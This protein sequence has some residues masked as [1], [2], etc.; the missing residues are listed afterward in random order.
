METVESIFLVLAYVA[1][2]GFLISGM[3]DLFFD[4]QFLVYLWRHRRQPH[5]TLN[6][7]KL[8]PEQWIA[9]FVPAWHEGGVVNKMAE[10]AARVL[11][12]ERYDIFI[13]VYP[14]DPHT[15]E[16]V[17]AIC[18]ANPRI[19]K[20]RV[21]HDGPTNKADCLNWIYRAMRLN[22]V[23][24]TREYKL[25]AI[26]DAEDVLHPLVLKV[27]NY[28]VPRHYDMA[29]LPV[30][31][32]ELPILKHWAGNTYVDDFS[33]LH[34]KDLF[35]R[36]AMGGV[37]PSAGVGTA[38]ARAALD[39][40]AAENNGDPFRVG[41]VTEDYEVGI[42]IKRAGFRTGVVS[43]PVERAVRRKRPDGTPAAPE[44]VTEIVATREA[45]PATFR[46]AVRQRTRWILGIS[47]QTWEQTGWAGTLPVRYTLLRDRRAPL[48]H[49]INMIGYVVLVWVVCQWLFRLT[50]WA[51]DFYLRPLFVPDSLLWK[52]TIIDT[53]LLGFR[54]VQKFVSVLHIYNWRQALCSIPRVAVGNLI[55]FIATVRAAALYA[56]HKL[57]GRPIVWHKTAHSFPGEAELAEYTKTIEDLLVEAGLVTREQIAQALQLEPS[58][59]APLRLLRLGLLGER[60]FTEIWA[61]HSG[62]PERFVDPAEVPGTL[63][64]RFPETRSLELEALPVAQKAEHVLVAFR[65]PP[66][67]ALVSNLERQF[68]KP[69]EAVLARPANIAFA[70]DHAYARL[71]L[72]PSRLEACLTRFHQAAN[73]SA[74][75]YLE[76]LRSRHTSRQSLPDVLVDKGLMSEPQAR[77]LWGECLDCFPCDSAEFA[78]C[79]ELYR[80]IGPPFW[81][82][83]R[84]LPITWG[85]IA[86]AAPLHPL[87]VEWLARKMGAQVEFVAELPGKFDLAARNLGVEVDP[88]QLLLDRLVA[89]GA[90]P[91]EQMPRL[92]SM[93]SLITDAVRQW[94]VLQR[95]VTE[96]QVHEAFLDICRLPAAGQWRAEEVRRLAPVLPPGFTEENGCYLLEESPAGLRVG[97]AQLPSASALR[98]LHDRLSGYALFFQ[99][100]SYEEVKALRALWR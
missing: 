55:N 57:L 84:M 58:G 5:L 62:L 39:R 98:K 20:V 29:Q 13:G 51:A 31:A 81:W 63:L 11:W 67:E 68:G 19:H 9:V 8:E 65:E 99:A 80:E 50:P 85:T 30:F 82:L 38:F 93:R 28:A 78:L 14:N 43:V 94:L 35:A 27:Y 44:T 89:R 52:I 10:Y 100:L 83:H 25:I 75:A 87:L 32:L 46:A 1:A 71:V 70:R 23:P 4:S 92:Q 86:T 54:A 64:R 21:P 76:A 56:G 60:H 7:L 79:A 16:C 95:L 96:E 24:G 34:T 18:A 37:V 17:D 26:H 48:T 97:L 53:C 91:R 88:D 69:V 49:V 72:A 47:F 33:E 59:S 36:Q 40:L 66:G 22:E 77:R 12:Y 3:D 42:R 45:F 41:N 73:A 74:D 15:N 6:Q 61:R 2:V 90:L